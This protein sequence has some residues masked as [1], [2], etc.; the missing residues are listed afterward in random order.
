M[1]SEK[2]EV[3]ARKAI[4]ITKQ[5]FIAANG[6]LAETTFK[7]NSIERNHEKDS[8]IVDC[9]LFTNPIA[10]KPTHYITRVNVSTREL[11]A[12]EQPGA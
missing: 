11:Q 6:R 8:W 12:K 2:S 3:D 1:E 7:V 4:E 9:Q 5:F 10:P